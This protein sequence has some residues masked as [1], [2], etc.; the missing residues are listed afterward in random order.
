MQKQEQFYTERGKW[1]TVDRRVV[2][3]VI[4][5]FVDPETVAT[6]Y[7]YTPD[8]VAHLMTAM[9]ST[10]EGGVPRS[11]GAPLLQAILEFKG[12]ADE[13]Y[14]ENSERLDRLHDSIADDEECVRYTLGEIACKGLNLAPDY[15]NDVVL[16]ATHQAIR[17]NLFFIDNDR[18]S[19]VSTHYLVRPRRVAEIVQTV[20][21]WVYDHTDYLLQRLAGTSDVERFRKYHPLQKFLDKAQRL[22]L[23]SR[24]FRSPTIVS[25]VGPSAQRFPRKPS[26]YREMPTEPFDANDR[27]IITFLMLYCIPPWHMSTVQ[28]RSA[29]AHIMRATQMYSSLFAN[30][31]S[32]P[33][34][35]QELGVFAPWE[36]LRVLDEYLG[37]SDHGISRHSDATWEKSVLEA[38]KLESL[39]P[40]SMVD[41]RTDWGDLPIYCIDDPGAH[42][43]DDG[44]SLERID[45]DTFWVRVH[46]ANPSAF[47]SVDSQ[48]IKAALERCQTVYLPERTYPMLPSILT[49]KH[50]SLTAG[51]PTLTF[52]AKMNI[53]GEVLDIDVRNGTARNAIYLTHGRLR[54]VFGQDAKEAQILRVGDDE[55]MNQAADGQAEGDFNELSAEDTSTFHTLRKLM[56]GFREWRLANGALEWPNH[57]STSITVDSGNESME[58]FNVKTQ[59]KHGR[60]FVGDPIISLQMQPD[61]NPHE[62][63]DLSKT[64]LVSLVMNLACWVSGRW[65]A[66][67]NIPAVYDGTWYHPEYRPLTSQNISQ[68]GGNKVLDYAPPMSTSSVEPLFH[69][70]LGLDAYIK[71]TSPLRRFSDLMTH[72]QIEAVLR[73]ESQFAYPETSVE[74]YIQHMRFRKS[75]ID[76]CASSSTQFW[77]C[78]LLFRA[79]YFDEYPL[80]AEFICILH[81]RYS[82]TILAAMGFDLGKMNNAFSGVMTALGVKCQVLVPD[83]LLGVDV[84]SVVRARIRSVDMARLLVVLEAT[85][86]VSRFKRVGEW[87]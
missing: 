8:V 83:A 59:A 86:L 26:V 53:K 61:M 40:D 41:L 57:P 28:M 52:S 55:D 9:Q 84:F 70:A 3:F 43:I 22:I 73:G 23:N 58:P 16:F 24:R 33:L 81:H 12:Q 20:N 60:Y 13:F 35:L 5:R 85:E 47:I 10:V 17:R 25:A 6:L 44:I 34:F 45:E 72:Y 65:C 36:N 54:E 49:Q 38:G 15:L 51:R 68:Y 18:G 56:L 30:P 48:I 79:F 1:C 21:Q 87:A 37:L 19:M 29:G 7:P 75:R 27:K 82:E 39:P 71:S 77:A 4:R 46:V 62:V 69:S 63:P 42:E 14:Q 67:R 78:Q 76:R 50:F 2:D 32:M 11:I 80:P 64:N 31:A 66:E 74:K